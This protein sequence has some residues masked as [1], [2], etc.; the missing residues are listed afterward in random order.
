MREEKATQSYLLSPSVKH[1][2]EGQVL[3]EGIHWE[4]TKGP[5]DEHLRPP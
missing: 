2:A 3:C 4:S 1:S 5:F